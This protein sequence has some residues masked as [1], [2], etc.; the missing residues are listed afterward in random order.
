VPLVTF[1]PFFV[2]WSRFKISPSFLAT[3]REDNAV[4]DVDFVK[5][6]ADPNHRLTTSKIESKNNNIDNCS[7]CSPFY[8]KRRRRLEKCNFFYYS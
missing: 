1:S 4:V 3:R 7:C 6:M 2:T 8:F 5:Y